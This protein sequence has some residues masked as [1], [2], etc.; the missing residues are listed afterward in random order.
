MVMAGE[1]TNGGAKDH[2]LVVDDDESATRAL[3]L[4]LGDEG[5]DVSVAWNGVQALEAMTQR[6]P[7]IVLSD[8]RMP[9]M[10][11]L[12]LL[13]RTRAL[14]PTVVVILMSAER[15][16]LTAAVD[17]GAHACVLK[18]IDLDVLVETMRIALRQSRGC[19]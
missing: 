5:F 11:G 16:T 3:E 12:E 2:V 15:T 4:L 6:T 7:A 18:P 19:A 17:S 13:R 1:P 10:N 9:R 8:V 14:Y